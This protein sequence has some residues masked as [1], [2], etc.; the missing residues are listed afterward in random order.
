MSYLFAFDAL[1][2]M[3]TDEADREVLATMRKRWAIMVGRKMP[4]LAPPQNLWVMQPEKRGGSD[5][6][7][8]RLR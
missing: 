8:F 2:Q 7:S 6:R 5:A 3:D 4:E 1:Y